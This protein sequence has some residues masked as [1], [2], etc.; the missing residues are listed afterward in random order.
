LKGLV[1]GATVA[2]ALPTLEIFLNGNGDAYASGSPLPK[3]FG[4][5]FW[6]NGNLPKRWL[7]TGEGAGDDWQLS[8]QLAPLA[9]LKSKISVVSGLKVYTGNTVPH[10]SGP[11]GMLSGAPFPKNDTS[12]FA[13]PSIDQVIAQAIGGDTRFRS[14][15]VGVQSDGTSLSYNG[16]HSLNPPETSPR[17]L[18]DRLFG[19]D[20]TPPGSTPKLDPRIPLRKSVLDAVAGDAERLRDRLG[21]ADKARLEQH[22][23]GIRALELQLQKIEENPPNLAACK[24]PAEPSAMFPD[25]D[26]RPQLSAISRAMTDIVV[27]ALACDMTRVFSDW[28]SSPVNNLLFPAAASGHH[29]LTHDE[30]GEQPQVNA[31]VV[32]IMN[33][34]AYLLQAMDAVPEGDGTLLDH[35]VVLATTDVSYGKSHSVEDYPIVLCGSAGGAIKTGLHY[36]SPSNENTSKMLLT[37]SRAMGLTLATYGQDAGHVDDG[38]SAVEA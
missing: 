34:L 7:P 24:L 21:A 13:V 10:G 22:L 30:P 5:F 29:Q 1:A 38:V 25:V 14:L 18:F 31:I 36:R 4:I 6:G 11:V 33:E 28:F 16:P 8:E 26:G 9:P 27:M 15:E 17:A 32:Y 3:R 37:L 2:V 35:S 20:F 12:T 23:A 19:T